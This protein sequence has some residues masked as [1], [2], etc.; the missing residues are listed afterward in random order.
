MRGR[1]PEILVLAAV[2]VVGALALAATVFAATSYSVSL[3]LQRGYRNRQLVA[4]G[5]THHYTFYHHAQ[6]VPF[7][8]YVRPAPGHSFRVK[9]KVKKC[10]SGAFK[11][12]FAI[13]V[14]GS[15]STGHFDGRLPLLRRGYYFARVYFYGVPPQTTAVA[16]S[17]KQFFRITR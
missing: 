3:N 5:I 11:T 6:H 7:D 2:T 4:C 16:R 9:V 12:V 17:A 13:H 1:K 8:G 15:A 14:R 10:R